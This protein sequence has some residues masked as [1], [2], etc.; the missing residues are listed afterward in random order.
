MYA[1]N[2]GVIVCNQ[3]FNR[4]ISL[5]KI[6]TLIGINTAYVPMQPVPNFIKYL[7]HIHKAQAFT[8]DKQQT[9]KSI[10]ISVS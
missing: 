9:F 10:K 5:L 1:C 8:S 3:L 7:R 2:A 6:I 4:V